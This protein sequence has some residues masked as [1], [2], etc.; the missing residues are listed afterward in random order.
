MTYDILLKKFQKMDE[1][2]TG[3]IT[4]FQLKKAITSCN[5]LTP[6]EINVIMRN[7]KEETFEYATFDKVLYDVRYELAKSRVMDTN[8]D[9]L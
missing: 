1:Q 3:F 9:K 2:N 7:I 4:P 5:L 8:I 6:K